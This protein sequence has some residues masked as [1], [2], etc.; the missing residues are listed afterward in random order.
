MLSLDL[1]SFV[2][3]DLLLLIFWLFLSEIL[4]LSSVVFDDSSFIKTASLISDPSLL[5]FEFSLIV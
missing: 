2:F 1:E 5:F 4:D 3:K